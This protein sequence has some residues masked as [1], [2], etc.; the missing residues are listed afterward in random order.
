MVEITKSAPGLVQGYVPLAVVADAHAVAHP[1]R[2]ATIY[3]TAEPLF[4]CLTSISKVS[5]GRH[6]DG[7]LEGPGRMAEAV[8]CCRSEAVS[9][10]GLPALHM[11]ADEVL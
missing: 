7:Y 11:T 1:K 3:K 8:L 10:Q 6:Q 2:L 9:T 4:G 5:P